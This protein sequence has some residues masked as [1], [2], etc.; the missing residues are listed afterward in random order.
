VAA[1]SQAEASA[2]V[3]AAV[4]SPFSKVYENKVL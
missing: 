3:A 1:V 2:A 4:F